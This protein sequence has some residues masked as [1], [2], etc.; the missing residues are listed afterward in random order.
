MQPCHNAIAFLCLY[1]YTKKLFMGKSHVFQAIQSCAYLP[2]ARLVGGS[3]GD[4]RS[5]QVLPLASQIR[6]TTRVTHK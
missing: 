3:H 5:C 6:D 1:P 2:S 4:L